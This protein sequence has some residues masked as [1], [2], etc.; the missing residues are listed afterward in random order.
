MITHRNPLA[1]A[2]DALKAGD[3]AIPVTGIVITFLDIM[4]VLQETVRLG[5]NLVISHE[6]TF[7]N[8]REETKPIADDP[9]YKEKLAY[10]EQH[11]IV[12]YRLHDTTDAYPSEDH[13]L[14]GI[15]SRPAV[16]GTP[17][18]SLAKWLHSP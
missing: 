5:D 3:P 1:D 8:H 11:H 15:R 10:I 18:F 16:S 4:A 7:Y 9:M 6:P 14:K 12:V 2:V 13:I 17:L